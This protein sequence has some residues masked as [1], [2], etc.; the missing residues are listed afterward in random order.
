MMNFRVADLDGLLEALK[1]EGVEI[2][3]HREDYE[4]GRFAGVMDPE[5]NRLELWEPPAGG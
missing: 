1:A 2:D 4:Y 5:G 3:P